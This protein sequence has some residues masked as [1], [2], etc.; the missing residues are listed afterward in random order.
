M[1]AV[2]KIWQL[3]FGKP[4]DPLDPRTRHAI[5]VTAILAWVGLGADGLSSSCY[6]PE[7]AFLALGQH[8]QLALFLALAT[9]A[10]VFIIALGYNQVIELF[11]TGGG[12]YRVATALLGPRL[13]LVSGAAL[14]VD[15]VLT[16]ATSL[17]SGVDAF[18]SLLPV[19]AQ[20]FK[21]ATELILI[22]LMT[23]L[24]FRGM[25]ESIMVLLPIFMGFVVLHLILIVYGVAVHGNH[26]TAVVPGA[27]A[28]AHSM[29]HAL[30]PLVVAALL[31]RAFSLGS[32]TYTRLEAVSNNVNMLAEPRVPA[33]KV[34]MF[35]MASSLAF[36]AGGIILL[37]ML[38]HA[39]PVEG[40]T[41]NAVVFGSVI[42]HLGL[43]SALA[44]CV[45]GR[46]ARARSGFVAGRRANRLSGRA[47]GAVEHGGRLMGAASF[48]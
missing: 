32:G 4:L 16:V 45:A 36:T 7:E 19:G 9:A 24:N 20:E 6:G 14:L 18:F 39:Q 48:P 3:V 41:L 35:Y 2:N 30:G 11:P 27:V 34:T 43:G 46:C 5:A 44:P 33:G 15:Y 37:Y 1:T 10:T 26:L 22:V 8:T 42:D 38:W 23:G 28:E 21:L 40:Q 25:R 12:G 31:M 29:S 13:G 17:A 47:G